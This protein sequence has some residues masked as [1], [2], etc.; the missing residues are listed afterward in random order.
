MGRPPRVGSLRERVFP[1]FF[2]SPPSVP[3]VRRLELSTDHTAPGSHEGHTARSRREGKRPRPQGPAARPR[4]PR[5]PRAPGPPA[6]ARPASLTPPARGALRPAPHPSPGERETRGC[7]ARFM[8]E[9]GPGGARDQRPRQ[10]LHP[11]PQAAPQRPALRPRG[12]ADPG[13]AAAGA[14]LQPPSR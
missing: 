6:R 14:S 5:G 8:G 3:P 1:S 2:W 9:S 4:G 10:E 11:E 13:P 12:R 7:A